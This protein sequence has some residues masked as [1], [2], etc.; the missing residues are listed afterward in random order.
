[1]A[2]DYLTEQMEEQYRESLN[3][4]IAEKAAILI[5]T[6]HY[7]REAAIRHVRNVLDF[8]DAHSN[9][10]AYFVPDENG[11]P[12]Q[13]LVVEAMLPDMPS[14]GQHYSQIKAVAQEI[15]HLFA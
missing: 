3:D 1:M 2:A 10:F 13:W 15:R 5:V 12:D 4:F 14:N 6:M 7:T 11:L 9:D 8:R